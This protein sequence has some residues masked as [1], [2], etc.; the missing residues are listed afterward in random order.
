MFLADITADPDSSS[1]DW[2]QGGTGIPPTAILGT[3]KAANA[4][5]PSP[6]NRS[7]RPDPA[8]LHRPEPVATSAKR[9][10]WFRIGELGPVGPDSALIGDG[11]QRP[12][13]PV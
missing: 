4:A 3:W 8:D 9:M 1:G 12:P 7:P 2:Q 11:G 13:E 10:W 5:N 6:N